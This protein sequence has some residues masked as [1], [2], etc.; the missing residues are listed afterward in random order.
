MLLEHTLA[1][2]H[3]LQPNSS[4]E[5]TLVI[6]NKFVKNA[7]DLK[8]P[9]LAVWGKLEQAKT[10]LAMALEPKEVL[11]TIASSLSD[12][13]PVYGGAGGGGGGGGVK[14]RLHSSSLSLLAAAWESYGRRL[15]A[16]LHSQL[17]CH[18]AGGE[19]EE[20]EGEAFALS[21]C[22]LARHLADQGEFEK[23][24]ALLKAALKNLSDTDHA[25]KL[26]ALCLG[27]VSFDRALNHGDAST[28]RRCLRNIA[29][30]DKLGAAHRSSVLVLAE[31][32]A[33]SA[34]R[35]THTL[36]PQLDMTNLEHVKLCA[37]CLLLLVEAYSELGLPAVALPHVTECLSH[38]QTHHLSPHPATL[39]LAQLQL[40]LGAHAECLELVKGCLIHCNAEG[41]LLERG[42]AG[43]IMAQALLC[44]GASNGG[45][46]PN[47]AVVLDALAMLSQA[48]ANLR[49][50][51]YTGYLERALIL[52][53]H[54]HDYIGYEAE[55]EIALKF[56]SQLH[57]GTS[58]TTA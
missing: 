43:L 21:V 19:E 28:A 7:E 23:A 24:V 34:V 5:D 13:L 26:M 40:Q 4:G 10:Q 27:E 50:S 45:N 29:T 32:D 18:T 12:F 3:K 44:A 33:Q 15:L 41:S 16:L 20:E 57:A 53:A 38:C 9:L 37:K 36:L 51:Q 47:K 14:E 49:K 55:K 25:Y 2:L 11:Q 46:A 56:L 22:L 52:Q 17:Q 31:G 58:S 8:L 48:V 6:L 42:R 1:W 30:F 39:W 54:L 35:Q